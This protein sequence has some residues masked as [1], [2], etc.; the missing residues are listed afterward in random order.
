MNVE[1]IARE[2]MIATGESYAIAVQAV[3]AIDKVLA[4]DVDQTWLTEWLADIAWPEDAAAIEWLRSRP[5]TMHPL[6][7]RFP[8][9]C[10]VRPLVPLRVPAAG[11]VGVVQSWFEDGSIGVAQKPDG[12]VRAQCR[13]HEIEVVGFWRGWT[14]DRMRE[15]LDSTP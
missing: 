11:T 6:M 8:P 12:L 7:L 15:V 5:S 4:A 1:S 3:L 9:S 2:R 10:V 13:A 14:C